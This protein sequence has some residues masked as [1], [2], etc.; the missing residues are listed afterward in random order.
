MKKV[1][2]VSTVPISLI[3][4]LKGQL[5]MLSEHYKV[6][7]VSSSGENLEALAVQEGIEVS[8]VDMERKISI[9]RDLKSLFKMVALLRREKPD[10]VHSITPKAGLISMLSAKIAGV[11][12]R[13]H[14]FTGLIFPTS[15]GF[16]KKLLILM[17]RLTCLCA[18]HIYPEG[19]G[20]KKDL[21]DYKI[22]SKPLN[23]IANGNINGIDTDYFNHEGFDGPSPDIFR[24]CFVGRMVGDKGIN[25]LIVAFEK[26][27]AKYPHTELI[28]VGPYE[29][30]LDPLLP[31]TIDKINSNKSIKTKGYQSDVRGFLAKS[32]IFVFPSY[33]EGFP[34]VVLQAGA[35]GLPQ[36]VTDISGCN[37]IIVEGKN[38]VIIPPQ[39]SQALYDKMEYML[40]HRDAVEAMASCAR[41]MIVSRYEQKYL[42]GELLKE[43]K[44]LLGE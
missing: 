29:S 1:I 41:E 4:L 44:K 21:Q 33:R 23:I 34:N 16:K 31:S 9:F 32:N 12:V 25:E 3:S 28:L 2:R 24:F 22:T 42:W 11:P 6:I 26:L 37:E 36:I 10:M 39:D 27:N 30:H 19:Q 8:A 38:G 43:Y 20:V 35:M 40:E 17:D 14:T 5:R 15:K 7:G 18:T 13:V